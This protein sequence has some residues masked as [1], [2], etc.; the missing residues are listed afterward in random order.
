MEPQAS[1]SP[2]KWRTNYTTSVPMGAAV[3][4]SREGSETCMIPGNSTSRFKV[5]RELKYI[6]STIAA[7]KGYEDAMGKSSI[8]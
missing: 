8:A 1:G 2:S 4:E 6:A 7:V 3:H 5:T